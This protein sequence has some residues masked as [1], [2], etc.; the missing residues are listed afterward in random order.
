VSL[1]G[2]LQE[3]ARFLTQI[4]SGP[5]ADPAH[6]V[7]RFV[8]PAIFW[9]V[10]AAVAFRQFRQDHERRDQ[11][12]G[13]AALVG[14]VR[15][16][17]LLV[18]EYGSHR[19]LFA[20]DA[21]VIF[22]P[23]LEHALELGTEVVAGYAFLAAFRG[24]A[25]SLRAFLFVGLGVTALLYVATGASWAAFV[26]SG[27]AAPGPGPRLEFALHWGDLAFRAVSTVA[28]TTIVVGLAAAPGHG[29]APRIAAAAFTGFLLDHL[30]MIASILGGG[31]YAWIL[32][33]L[34]H[35][36]HMWAVPIL[37][38]VYWYELSE[39]VRQSEARLQQAKKLESLG[40]LAGGVAHD[41]NNLLTIVGGNLDVAL[42][43]LA[44]GQARDLVTEARG[45]ATRAVE[46]TAQLL[47]YAGKGQIHVAPVNVSALAAETALL[48]RSSLGRGAHLVVDCPEG[49]PRVRADVTQL[50]QLLMNLLL[51]AAQAMDGRTGEIAIRTSARECDRGELSRSPI[52]EG[53][54]AGAYVSIQ[55][56]DQ[57]VGMTDETRA[58]IFD[59]FFTTRSGGRGLGLAVVMGAVKGHRGA[60]SVESTPGSGTTFTVLLPADGSPSGTAGTGTS[61]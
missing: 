32:A 56:S 55:V 47:A 13:I 59:P 33:P 48:V 1:D 60:L 24:R 16:L 21:V 15:E 46:L 20:F 3:I 44:P 31:R 52:G 11:L 40:L 9:A 41:F 17:F 19:G 8:I 28:L 39:T 10:L 6:A 61:P 49:L 37:L 23:P 42:M 18:V 36:L 45:G 7:P 26:A 50:R 58:R 12:L 51:N 35:N 27:H 53:L 38:G 22:Y 34:R 4:G 57:G 25:P 30:L 54:P 43:D 2:I 29:I 14:L 5:G